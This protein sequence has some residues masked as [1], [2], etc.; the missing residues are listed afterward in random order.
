MPKSKGLLELRLVMVSL[1]HLPR[2]DEG[3]VRMA[4]QDISRLKKSAKYRKA[5]SQ[6]NAY[7]LRRSDRLI[8][9]EFLQA[10]PQAEPTVI[11]R[12][13]YELMAPFR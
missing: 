5:L 12:F 3:L 9:I 2:Q 13:I 7:R 4:Q 10:E 8:V 6:S 11:L 1:D